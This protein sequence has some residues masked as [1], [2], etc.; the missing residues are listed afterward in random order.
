MAENV[1]SKSSDAAEKKSANLGELMA[2]IA[3][4]SAENAVL[5]SQHD[6]APKSVDDNARRLMPPPSLNGEKRVPVT[7]FLDG[8]HYTEDVYVGING[9]GFQIKRGETVMVPESVAKVLENANQQNIAAYRYMRDKQE[10]YQK[11][12]QTGK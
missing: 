7:L 3:V 1:N 5:K 9:I 2:Q 10:E 11:Q 6:N 4:L 12:N 8:D